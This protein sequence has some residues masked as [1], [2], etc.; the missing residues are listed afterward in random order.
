[1][2][3]DLD[4]PVDTLWSLLYD[5]CHKC[6]SMILTNTYTNKHC[7]PWITNKIKQLSRQKQKLC[8]SAHLTNTMAAWQ[9]YKESKK[10]MQ[11]LCRQAH[12]SYIQKLVDPETGNATKLW[13]YVK[14][15]KKDYCC[16]PPLLHNDTL[17]TDSYSKANIL[18]DYLSSVF[19]L[20]DLDTFPGITRVTFN[21][22]SQIISIKEP[23]LQPF[24]VIAPNHPE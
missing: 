13:S 4:T 12:N 16:V 6:L 10:S 8:N 17:I 18:N 20:E 3:Y 14:S 19:V 24:V 1:M 2:T 7:P 9:K 21:V 5:M 22:N 11:Q 15:Q 23:H